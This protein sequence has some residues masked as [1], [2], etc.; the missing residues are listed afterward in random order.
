[1]E[2]SLREELNRAAEV[3]ALKSPRQIIFF[4]DRVLEN[5]FFKLS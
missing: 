3:V 1:M 4:F 2:F 5:C